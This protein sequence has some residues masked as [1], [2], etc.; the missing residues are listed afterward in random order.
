MSRVDYRSGSAG[1][2][3]DRGV[4]KRLGGDHDCFKMFKTVGAVSPTFQTRGGV[5]VYRNIA[6]VSRI[7]TRG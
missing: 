7:G 1:I 2:V 4:R 6:V 5:R 3:A